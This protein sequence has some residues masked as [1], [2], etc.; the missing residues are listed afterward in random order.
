MKKQICLFALLSLILPLYSANGQEY[1]NLYKD[2]YQKIIKSVV[3]IKAVQIGNPLLGEAYTPIVGSG[4]IISAEGLIATNKHVIE[5]A[6]DIKVIL[7]DN[8]ELPAQLVGESPDIDI[9]IIKI[10]S[11]PPNLEPIVL[12]DSDQVQPGEIVLALGNPSGLSKTLTHGIISSIGRYVPIPGEKPTP[13]TFFQTDAAINPGNS[14]GALINL[15]GELVGIPT[16]AVPRL[17][18]ISFA[19]PVNILKIILPQILNQKEIG[20]LGVSVQEL[21]P[22]LREA[23]GIPKDIGGIAVTVVDPL[24]P[25]KNKLEQLDIILKIDG[26]ELSQKSD[27]EWAVRNAGPGT[28]ILITVFKYKTKKTETFSLKTMPAPKN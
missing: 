16:L 13:H 19:I 4:V 15:N 17:Q 12:G 20:W 24:S 10:N 11:P 27:Y 21:T 22:D 25:A 7:H 2:V 5:R 23:A 18:N 14:G 6:R 28:T 9:A 8:Q 26:K 3:G 1:R